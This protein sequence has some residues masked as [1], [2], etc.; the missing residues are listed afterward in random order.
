MQVSS[1]P[2]RHPLMAGL[3]CGLLALALGGCETAKGVGRD[4]QSV[5][6]AIEKAV[7]NAQD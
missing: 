2:A 6:H 4:L 5:G 7:H 3:F 1:S